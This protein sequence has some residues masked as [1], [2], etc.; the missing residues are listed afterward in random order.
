MV[1]YH[2]F[3]AKRVKREDGL[4]SF[5]RRVLGSLEIERGEIGRVM[6]PGAPLMNFNDGEVQQRF[7]F[8]TQKITTSEF[9]YPKKTL[10]FS[11]YPRKSLDPF[12]ATQKNPGVFHRV[13]KITPPPIIKICEWGPWGNER[14]SQGVGEY[15]EYK[16]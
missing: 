13:K 12:F 5:E 7:I 9:V 1:C 14:G 4:D 10:L 3:S 11:A 2:V 15:K 8:Y 6:S 16:G